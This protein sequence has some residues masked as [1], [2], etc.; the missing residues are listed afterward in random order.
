M[1][2]KAMT[3]SC[4]ACSKGISVEQY[5]QTDEGKTYSDCKS[6]SNTSGTTTKPSTTGTTTKP[7]SN[8]TTTKP[9]SQGTSGKD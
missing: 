9:S 1:C 4:N 3:A 7:S 8:D 6:Y 5:C 2:C